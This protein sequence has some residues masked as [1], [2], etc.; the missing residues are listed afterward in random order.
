M[1]KLREEDEDEDNQNSENPS[2]ANDSGAAPGIP[3][4]SSSGGFADFSVSPMEN[5]EIMSPDSEHLPSDK[6]TL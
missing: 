2:Q 5:D 4:S 1:K 6:K 3:Q